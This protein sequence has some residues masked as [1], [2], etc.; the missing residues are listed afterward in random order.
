MSLFPVLFDTN[1]LYGSYINDLVLR[2]AERRLFRPLWSEDILDELQNALLRDRPE[3]AHGALSRRVEAMRTAFP[4][5]IVQ[6]YHSLV[7]AMTCDPKDRHVLAAAVRSN[8][9]LLVTFN[10]ADFPD[11]STSPFRIEVVHPDQFL[12]DQLDLH[13]GQTVRVVKQLLRDYKNPPTDTSRY[14]GRLRKSGLPDFAAE[15]G[16]YLD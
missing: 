1:V 15:L 7:P 6:G 10:L 5:A 14:L 9:A 13:P 12:I 11:D 8:A 4:D 2:L 16:R 3:S